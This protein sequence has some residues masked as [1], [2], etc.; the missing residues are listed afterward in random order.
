[1]NGHLIDTSVF[2]KV[3]RGNH[4]AAEFLAGLAN[5]HV[6]ATIIGELLYGALKSAKPEANIISVRKLIDGVHLLMIGDDTAAIYAKI[7][8][9][10]VRE[11]FNLPENDLWIAATAKQNGLTVA[12]YDSHF[13]QIKAIETAY[14]GE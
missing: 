14:F 12:T 5:T 6:S 2:V 13:R 7:R 11:G 1:M 3:L 10:L 4:A 8:N 9:E